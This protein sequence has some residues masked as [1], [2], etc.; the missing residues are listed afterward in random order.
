MD[1]ERKRDGDGGRDEGAVRGGARMGEWGMGKV[2]CA[3]CID[4]HG[5]VVWCDVTR[6]M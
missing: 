1:G 3:M 5:G 4:G 2:Q 6:G